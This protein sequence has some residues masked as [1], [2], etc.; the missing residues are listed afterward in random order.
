MKVIVLTWGGLARVAGERDAKTP[1]SDNLCRDVR[2]NRKKSAEVI[3]PSWKYRE[4]GSK[5]WRLFATKP[6]GGYRGSQLS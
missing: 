4:S 6:K 2:L 3:V 1:H 5:D